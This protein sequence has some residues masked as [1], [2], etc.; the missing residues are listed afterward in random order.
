M[1]QSA[2]Q[3]PNHAD[4]EILRAIREVRYGTV[5]ITIHDSKVVQIARTEKLRLEPGAGK[6]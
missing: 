4:R 1:N 5:E 2:P 6:G 3:P